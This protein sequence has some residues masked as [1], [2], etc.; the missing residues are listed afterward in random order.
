MSGMKKRTAKKSQRSWIAQWK[1]LKRWQQYTFV[2]AVG[3]LLVVGLVSNAIEGYQAR[4]EQLAAQEAAVAEQALQQE[5][6][7]QVQALFDRVAASSGYRPRVVTWGQT[8]TLT[9]EQGA[10][11][12]LSLDEGTLLQAWMR[13]QYGE[14]FQ[15][16]IG[17]RKSADVISMD[18]TVY[19]Y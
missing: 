15:I 2:G 9:M 19:P 4:Q 13:G 12:A 14:G 11:F 5:R 18:Q 7:P 16:I 10:Y 3:F 17:Q 1:A 8:P 6:E